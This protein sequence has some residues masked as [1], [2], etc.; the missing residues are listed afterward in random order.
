[1][2]VLMRTLTCRASIYCRIR[3]ESLTLD[4]LTTTDAD[5]VRAQRNALQGALDRSDFLHIAGDLRQV[6]VDQ[7]V[8]KGLILQIADAAG[9][10]GIAFVVGPRE[11]LARLVPQFAP[12]IPQLVLEV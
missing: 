9:N 4:G 11:H 7:Q 8:G 1:M 2:G 10:I 6:D 12:S 3:L 5:T